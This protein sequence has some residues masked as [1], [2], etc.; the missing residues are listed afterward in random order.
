MADVIPSLVLAGFSSP[1]SSSSDPKFAALMPITCLMKE[2]TKSK[3]TSVPLLYAIH[4]LV[5]AVMKMQGNGD[6]GKI[7]SETKSQMR[8][9]LES[10]K[11]YLPSLFLV[12]FPSPL[13]YCFSLPL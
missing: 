4:S 10:A 8:I 7:I 2:F 12:I 3:K 5:W 9:L 13:L 11:R 6:F 1:S